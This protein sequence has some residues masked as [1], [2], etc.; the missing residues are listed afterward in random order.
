MKGVAFRSA[1]DLPPSPRA[2][3]HKNKKIVKIHWKNVQPEHPHS[4]TKGETIW[5]NIVK[6]KVDP[7]KLE[8]F[9]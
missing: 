8:H 2:D 1:V 4:A 7:D 9:F 5:K 6:V 3:L